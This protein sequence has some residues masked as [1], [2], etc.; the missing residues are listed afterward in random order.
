MDDRT[1]VGV[2]SFSGAVSLFELGHSGSTSC[3]VYEGSSLAGADDLS[4]LMLR[5]SRFVVALK[6]C[7]QNLSNVLAYL[8]ESAPLAYVPNPKFDRVL[9]EPC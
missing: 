6:H 2:L 3:E 7:R 8:V 9:L 5:Q 4:S 1:R